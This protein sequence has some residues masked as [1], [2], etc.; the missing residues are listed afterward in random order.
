MSLQIIKTLKFSDKNIKLYGSINEPWF[1]GKHICDCMEIKKHRDILKKL[2]SEYKKQTS[3]LLDGCSQARKMTLINE[4]GLY[5]LAFMSQKKEAIQFKKWCC[6]VLVEIRKTGTYKMKPKYI[7]DNFKMYIT[8][9]QQLHYQTIRSLRELY[10]DV[11]IVPTLGELQDTEDKRL[12]A[13]NKG[14]VAGL[15][16]IQIF[17]KNLKLA[18][19]L[20]SPNGLND[21]SDKQHEQLLRFKANGFICIVSNNLL[22]LMKQINDLYMRERYDIRYKSSDGLKSFKTLKG[23]NRYEATIKK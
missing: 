3:I 7:K 12:D 8:N 1:I 19:E 13:Y 10:P 9:E 17:Y 5:M 11:L 20:K 18:I 21:V 23:L 2:D 14:Y 15:P 16:D 22:D 4:E 6:G